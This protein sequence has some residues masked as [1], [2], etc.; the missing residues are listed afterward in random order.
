[1]PAT[2]THHQFTIDVLK[3]LDKSIEEQIDVDI[4]NLFGKSFDILFFSKPGLGFYAHNHNVNLYFQIILDYIKQNNLYQSPQVLAYLYGSIC[5]YVLDSTVHPF[6]FYKTGKYISSDKSTKKYLGKHNYMEYMIDAI[7]FQEK[8]N[9]PIYKTNLKKF[10]FPKLAFSKELLG[11]IDY[12]YFNTFKKEHAGKII[13]KGYRNYKFAVKYLMCSRFGIKK[14]LYKVLDFFPIVRGKK[15]SWCCYHIKK[16]DLSVL[17]LEHKIWYYPVDKNISYHYSFY[18]LY[19]IA[20][21]RA[22]NLIMELDNVFRS[23]DPDFKKV[24][25]NIGNLNYSTGKQAD[26]NFKMRHF[27]Y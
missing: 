6:V 19:D 15:P 1:M 20:I 5:H 22:R 12:A 3:S 11:T 14:I 13:K 9:I 2:Y 27:E 7:L 18:D 25:R 8:N 21:E 16:F 23:Q 26:K 4:F 17:N 10:I 24:L